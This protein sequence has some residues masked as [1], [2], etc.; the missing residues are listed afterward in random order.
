MRTLVVD[1][2]IVSKK[3]MQKIM[4][5]FGEC[6]TAETGM[7]AL[8][9]YKD[10]LEK[11]NP[12]DL[13]TLDII[14]PDTDGLRTLKKIRALEKEMQKTG[15]E[16]RQVKIMMVTSHSERSLV[17]RCINA[18]CNNYIVKPFAKED[19]MRKLEEMAFKI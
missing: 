18:G 10:S 13:I 16:L 2:E 9:A 14:I 6:E 5:T 7:G 12:F 15:S 4:E 19:I 3:K 8:A 1:D 11:G 17:M